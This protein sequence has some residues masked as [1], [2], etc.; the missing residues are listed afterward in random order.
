MPALSEGQS[1][2]TVLGDLH[3]RSINLAN[4][5]PNTPRS[6]YIR[7]GFI[8]WDANGVDITCA[9]SRCG[10]RPC[11]LP[12]PRFPRQGDHRTGWMANKQRD[13][14]DRVRCVFHQS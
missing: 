7:E 8:C 4:I 2:Q 3:A 11:R 1:I 13:H 5:V 9:V 10:F 14:C 12:C 6:V